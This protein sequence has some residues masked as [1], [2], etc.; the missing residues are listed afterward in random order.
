M[1]NIRQYLPELFTEPGTLLYIGARPDAHSW[2]D[3]F[4]E[5]GHTITVLEIW[6]ENVKGLKQDTRFE[7]IWDD[8]RDIE[9]RFPIVPN[10][11]YVI[12]WHGPEH[13][14]PSELEK[15]LDALKKTTRKTLAVATPY[16]IYK[17]GPSNGNP[18]EEHVA[19]VYPSTLEWFGFE[20]ATDGKANVPG[21]E[22]VGWIRK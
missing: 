10:F 19:A 21:G 17:Q 12:W 20:T 14:W 5:A 8:V 6:P 18:Y 1:H 2:L 3:E 15:T 13:V 11:D 7:T 22:V 4:I 9:I 16:G